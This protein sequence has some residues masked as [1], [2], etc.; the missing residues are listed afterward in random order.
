MYIYSKF[1]RPPV[2]P[3]DF[4]PS[5]VDL[6]VFL[7]LRLAVG[8]D[9]LPEPV[10]QWNHRRV[11]DRETLV[12]RLHETGLFCHGPEFKYCQLLHVTESMHQVQRKQKELESPIAL[13][14][15]KDV[16]GQMRKNS[17]SSEGKRWIKGRESK[18]DYINSLQDK[19][20]ATRQAVG[21]I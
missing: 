7:F 11:I 18:Q 6:R 2:F 21:Q 15:P 3:Q 20:A 17:A 1:S 14:L 4:P 10:H 19:V 9:N 5:T 8:K 13:S 12:A 16:Q